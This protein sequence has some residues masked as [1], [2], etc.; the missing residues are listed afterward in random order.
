MAEITEHDVTAKT[1]W[2]F[3]LLGDHVSVDWEKVSLHCEDRD[4][5]VAASDII[6]R[7]IDKNG[8]LTFIEPFHWERGN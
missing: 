4:L 1:A 6:Q 3:E 8:Y 2:F 5:A 7:Q